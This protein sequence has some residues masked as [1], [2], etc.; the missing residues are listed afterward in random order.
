MAAESRIR[1]VALKLQAKQSAGL[2][3]HL[4]QYYLVLLGWY[5]CNAQEPWLWVRCPVL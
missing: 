1:P 5:Q 2:T 3:W 4:M